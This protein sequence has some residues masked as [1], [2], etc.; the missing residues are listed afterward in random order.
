MQMG[1][2]LWQTPELENGEN[3]A[4]PPPAA[5]VPLK[6]NDFARQAKG[7][8]NQGFSQSLAKGRPGGFYKR[9]KIP[10]NPP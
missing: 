5:A 4:P 6:P 7:L 3:V 1:K 10:L 8:K 2:T 9:L